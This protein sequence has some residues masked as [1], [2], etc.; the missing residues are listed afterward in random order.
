MPRLLTALILVMALAS[1]HRHESPVKDKPA[2]P[3]PMTVLVYMAANTNLNDASDLNE[4]LNAA[5][6]GALSARGRVMVYH[7]N[8]RRQR[9]MELTPDSFATVVQFPTDRPATD[10]SRLREVIDATRSAAPA[11][12]FGL[13]LWSHATGWVGTD[14]PSQSYAPQL[15]S[16]GSADRSGLQMDIPDL[17][18]ALGTGE[19]EFIYF[20][21]CLMMGA[22]VVYELRHAARYLCGSVTETPGRGMPYD[23]SLPLL[24][25]GTEKSLAAN[26][27]LQLEE[28]GRDTY[29]SCPVSSVVIRTDGIDRLAALTAA[30]FAEADARPATGEDDIQHFYYAYNYPRHKFVDMEQY[31]ARCSGSPALTE[32]WRAALDRVVVANV[33]STYIWTIWPIE[34]HCGLSIRPTND[35]ALGYHR[36]QWWNDVASYLPSAN[37]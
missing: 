21:C 2:E 1:C 35:S 36:L 19:F 25:E 27:R 12:R 6:G 4:M 26:A 13:V 17:G 15:R 30:I 23:R 16:F 18:A 37:N 3:V 32:L 5:R 20:D 28:Y 24:L 8:G 10:A 34:H 7:D 22:E 29:D 9:L 14:S 31:V 33:H 11:D